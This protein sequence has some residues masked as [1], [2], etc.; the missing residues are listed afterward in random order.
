MG[1][2]LGGD[3]TSTMGEEGVSRVGMG[4]PIGEG[5][6]TMEGCSYIESYWDT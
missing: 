2:F 1:T 4:A 5:D 6:S 3:L